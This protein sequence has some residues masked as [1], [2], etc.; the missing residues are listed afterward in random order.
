MP[1]RINGYGKW[2]GLLAATL[3]VL[4][5]LSGWVTIADEPRVRTIAR[6]EASIQC[7][8]RVPRIREIARDEAKTLSDANRE[9]LKVHEDAVLG[10]L[11]DIKAQLRDQG[12][13]VEFLKRRAM[14][15]G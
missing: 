1:V 14:V 5:V 8:L 7:D 10:V 6:E 9:R 12:E 3:G 4:A 2:V 15:G 11:Q 13:S